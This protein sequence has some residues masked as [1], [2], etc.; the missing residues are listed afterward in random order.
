MFLWKNQALHTDVLHNYGFLV[1]HVAVGIA[2]NEGQQVYLSKLLLSQLIL[3]V[4]SHSSPKK[5]IFVG[6]RNYSIEVSERNC[7]T[8]NKLKLIQCQ[9]M[10]QH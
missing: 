9:E 10:H 2:N 3:S 6:C 7:A 5:E 1:G 8:G 4:S